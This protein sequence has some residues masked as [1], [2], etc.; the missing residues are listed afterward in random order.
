MT[1]AAAPAT[2]GA[3]I[4][5]LD[6]RGEAEGLVNF[7][8]GVRPL[9]GVAKRLGGIAGERELRRQIEQLQAKS[10]GQEVDEMVFALILERANWNMQLVKAMQTKAGKL[11]IAAGLY[12]LK[13]GVVAYLN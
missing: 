5:V 3:A 6:K 10:A 12:D 13:T 9:A 8:A 2:W 11:K 7:L 4:E 1:R